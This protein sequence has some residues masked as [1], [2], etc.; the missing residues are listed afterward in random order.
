MK[1]AAFKAKKR[2]GVETPAVRGI[3]ESMGQGKSPK[4][5]VKHGLAIQ[6][7]QGSVRSHPISTG[8]KGDLRSKLGQ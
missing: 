8:G 5:A 3:T 4:H 1:Q 7:D 2:E 6:M